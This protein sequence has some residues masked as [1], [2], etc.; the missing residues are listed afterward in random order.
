MIRAFKYKLMVLAVA[1]AAF[2]SCKKSFLELTPPTV[3]TPEQALAAESDLLVALRGI[4]ASYRAVDFYGRTVPV[5]G[6]L[7]ADNSYLSVQ[8]TNRY[9]LFYNYTFNVTDGNIEGLWN[10]AYNTILRANNVINST[11]PANANVNQYR[12]EAYA[13]RALAYFTLVRAFAKPYTD[14]PASLGVPI[15]TTYNTELKPT[16]NTVSEVYTLI[17]ADL[18]QAYS[19]MS[20]ATFTNSSQFSKFAARGLQAKVY[21]TMGDK[22]NAK[23]AAL[24]VI[25][26]GGF[27]SVTAANYVAYWQN[28]AI[29]STKGETLY[30]VS[31]DAVNNLAFDA[32]SYLYS[33]GG[34]YGDLLCSDA[35]YALF[36]ATDVRRG[37]YPTGNRP[38]GVPVVFVEKYPSINGDRSDTK[39]LRL[40]EMYLIAAEASLPA[41][42]ADALTYINYITS[43]RNATAIASTGAALLEDVLT[44]RR[45]ELAFEG[46][47]YYDLQRLKRDVQ[48]NNNYPASAQ[49]IA[50][51]NF[52]RIFPIPQR[53]LN[54]NPNIRTQQN[55]GY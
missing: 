25:T 21:L 41:N 1:A 22:A 11:V 43:R 38:A 15:I 42:E 32:L 7:M 2:T 35:L 47:R 44:E 24:D 12:G 4:Y 49:T 5:L 18:T 13:L 14:A 30:E 45:K 40:S 53:E 28:P 16:R 27:V 46:D 23:T 26:N 48:R 29:S 37:L 3:L 34:N 51:T 19:L 31:S 36:S 8:N 17:Q 52:R 10:S 6:D 55:S 50:F 54:A 39:V 33:Q 9:T 20:A